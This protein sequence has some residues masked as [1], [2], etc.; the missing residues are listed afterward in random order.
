MATCFGPFYC[1]L[2][3]QSPREADS[4]LGVEKITPF[5]GTQSFIMVLKGARHWTV[6]SAK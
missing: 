2:I 4:C 1:T 6:F 3:Q 5:Y